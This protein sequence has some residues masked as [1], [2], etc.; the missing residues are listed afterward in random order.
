HERVPAPEVLNGARRMAGLHRAWLQRHNLFFSREGMA[1]PDLSVYREDAM[2]GVR[3]VA[4]PDGVTTP[5]R[6]LDGGFLRIDVKEAEAAL[7]Q[8]VDAVI[9]RL[10]GVEDPDSNQLRMDWEAVQHSLFEEPQLCARLGEMG[11]DPYDAAA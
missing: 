10:P 8:F 6:F 2:V 4:D 11:L 7:A 3:W 9:E 1:Y 5:G